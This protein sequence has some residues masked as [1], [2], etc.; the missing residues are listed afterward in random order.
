MN[1]HPKVLS[2]KLNQQRLRVKRWR[3]EENVQQHTRPVVV[4]R[5]KYGKGKGRGFTMRYLAM[6]VIKYKP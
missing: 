1:V 6:W 2:S 5:I 4:E 3:T